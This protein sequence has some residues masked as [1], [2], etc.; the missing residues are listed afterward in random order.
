[1]EKTLTETEVQAART[2]DIPKGRVP[3]SASS[4]SA[5]ISSA[6]LLAESSSLKLW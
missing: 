4:M 2:K 1:M 5:M 6:L 3:C